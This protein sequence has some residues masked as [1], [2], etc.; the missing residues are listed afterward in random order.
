MHIRTTATSFSFVIPIILPPSSSVDTAGS[1]VVT[2]A[3]KTK[4][5]IHMFT[6]SACNRVFHDSHLIRQIEQKEFW[7]KWSLIKG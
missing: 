6:V 3:L 7:Q 4:H 2:P 1:G 5:A